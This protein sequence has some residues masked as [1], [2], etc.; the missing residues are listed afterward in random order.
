MSVSRSCTKRST[1]SNNQSCKPV[2]KNRSFAG[3]LYGIL[4]TWWIVGQ[5]A[6]FIV[7]LGQHQN[8][9]LLYYLLFSLWPTNEASIQL[10]VV[11]SDCETGLFDAVIVKR[12]R[13]GVRFCEAFS[14]QTDVISTLFLNSENS[15][16]KGF[17]KFAC[18][19]TKGSTH[20]KL[21]TVS[22][23]ISLNVFVVTE[24]S[25]FA[26]HPKSSA[27]VLLIITRNLSDTC[28]VPQRQVNIVP[29][30]FVTLVQRNGRGRLWNNPK[31]EQ[32]SS[33]SHRITARFS[34]ANRIWPFLD[35]T[36]AS[37]LTTGQGNEGSGNEIER[38][39]RTDRN[40]ICY[41]LQQLC[42][43][44]LISLICFLFM[45]NEQ[46]ENLKFIKIFKSAL[47][48]QECGHFRSK[49]WHVL[50]VRKDIKYL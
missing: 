11:C 10:E 37:L 21:E 20:K 7:S 46:F 38:Q 15:A 13:I 48:R 40:A 1:L 44:Q 41:G 39:V 33:G 29:R 4:K 31:A 5:S 49:N 6:I 50:N 12:F 28:S 23:G 22:G 8:R 35:L 30:T 14:R 16:F 26:M 36:R 9:I 19:Y 3:R 2:Q 18:I 42:S 45:Y 25:T 47:F 27:C 24:R 34:A 17:R 32:E 43:P